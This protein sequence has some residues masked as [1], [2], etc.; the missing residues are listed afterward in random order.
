LN[1]YKGGYYDRRTFI[2]IA[3]RSLSAPFIGA[4]LLGFTLVVLVHRLCGAESIPVGV[5]ELV[6]GNDNLPKAGNAGDRTQ[7]ACTGKLESYLMQMAAG[8][9]ALCGKIEPQMR[10]YPYPAAA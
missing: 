7:A 3:G 2:T 4:R 10:L 1:L 9:A 5:N 8:C 6:P